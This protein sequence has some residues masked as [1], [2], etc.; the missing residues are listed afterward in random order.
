MNIDNS[1][2]SAIIRDK[3]FLT[4]KDK[5]IKASFLYGEDR[6]VYNYLSEFYAKHG[7]VPTERLVRK[8]FPDYPLELHASEPLSYWCDELRKKT[9]HNYIAEQYQDIGELMTNF[10]LEEAYTKIKSIVRYVEN[11]I[12]ESSVIDVTKDAEAR[13]EVYEKRKETK[14]MLGISSGI[15][16][17]DYI[18]KGFQPKTL[19]TL[20]AGTGVGKSWFYALLAVNAILNGSKVMFFT[21]EMSEEQLENRIESLLVASIF[22]NFNY[23]DFISG[24]LNA[25]EEEKYY[26][27]LDRKE[28]L[29]P[30]I[31]DTA[32]S[33]AYV[34]ARIEE[35]KPDIVFIDSA[36]LMS[37]DQPSDSDWLRV[38]HI[39]R[40]LKLIAKRKRIPILINSQAD[41][42]TSLKKGPEMGNIGFSKYIG[43]DSDVVLALFRDEYMIEDHE[44]GIKILKQREGALGKLFMNWDF[45]TMNFAPID[46][47][48]SQGDDED[49]GVLAL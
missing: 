32:N 9:Q 20:I 36:Y 35:E 6:K 31:I 21:T 38:V 10:Q 18:L 34:E 47:R 7:A 17:L 37:D 19:I 15:P 12:I 22:G 45:R 44:M 3:D 41:N 29:T 48:T 23:N 42:T 1:F 13:K 30:L 43:A 8:Q 27:M 28:K 25:E 40:A 16:K 11:E 2:I 49:D 39:T 5:Q 4:V 33:P 46:N 26:K 24:D 14:G